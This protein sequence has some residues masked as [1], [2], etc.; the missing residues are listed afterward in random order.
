MI[1]LA[2]PEYHTDDEDFFWW[3]HSK[4]ANDYILDYSK[5]NNLKI[6]AIHRI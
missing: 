6:K 4:L 2:Y 3:S 5:R 1:V